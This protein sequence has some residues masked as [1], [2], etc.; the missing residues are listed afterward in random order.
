MLA[1]TGVGGSSRSFRSAQ[2]GIS[3]LLQTAR[4]AR[5]LPAAGDGCTTDCA[6]NSSMISKIKA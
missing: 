1:G 4:D 3:A 6:T 5:A 2:S